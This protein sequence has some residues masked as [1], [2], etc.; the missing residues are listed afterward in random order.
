MLLLGKELEPL[1]INT[2]IMYKINILLGNK[3]KFDN[4]YKKK[5]NRV[6]TCRIN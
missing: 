1:E 3:S 2:H 5:I 6:H 4:Y